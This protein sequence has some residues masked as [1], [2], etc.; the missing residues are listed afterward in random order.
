LLYRNPHRTERNEN[1]R[2][3]NAAEI[4][5]PARRTTCKAAR[6]NVVL[7]A[8]RMTP[9]HIERSARFHGLPDHNQRW[10]VE[11]ERHESQQIP[12]RT[13]HPDHMRIVNIIGR[14]T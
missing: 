11:P 12:P 4:E 1:K 9:F 8:D 2:F 10:M 6:L 3:L 7:Q 14:G 5:D 13:V